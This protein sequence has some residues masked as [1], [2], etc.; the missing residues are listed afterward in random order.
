MAH[1]RVDSAVVVHVGVPFAF[2]GA[3]LTRQDACMELSMHH[4]VWRFSLPREHSRRR[5]ANIGAV[6][7]GADA[8]AKPLEMF[9]FTEA[10]ICARRARFRTGRQC[11]KRVS[12]IGY[13]LLITARVTPQHEFD[14]FHA[15]FY[16]D[17]VG[18]A[19][20]LLPFTK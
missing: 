17:Q 10:C 18:V 4:L 12:V 1:F 16:R 5:R 9:G 7:I 15:G 14:G 6:K 2:F 3:D 19:I 8:A 13:P 20:G 11:S